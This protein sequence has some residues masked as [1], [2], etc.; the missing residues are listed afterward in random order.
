[1]NISCYDNEYIYLLQEREF[2]KTNEPIYKIG[3]SKQE[4]LK[5]IC[6]YPNGTKL[7]F[8][9]ICNNC[10]ILEKKLIAIFKTKYELQKEIGL[11]YFKGN[12]KEMIKDIY[13]LIFDNDENDKEVMIKNSNDE[14][15]NLTVL[16]LKDKCKL[17]G[18]SGYSSLTKD[19]IIDLIKSSLIEINEYSKITVIQLKDKCKSLGISGYSKLTKDEL[20]DLI[21]ESLL[22]FTVLQLKEL[23]KSLE[24]SGYSKL[25]KDEIIDLIKYN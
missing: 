8:Q 21:E 17:L 16:Q 22:K 4:N 6:N 20:L 14:Y 3:K 25:T 15:S 24:I 5:R 1:M 23:C 19:E 13:K 18:I 12:Y 7:I 11:E 10:D 9:T 2:I